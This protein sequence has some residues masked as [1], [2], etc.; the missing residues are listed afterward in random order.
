[1]SRSPLELIKKFKKDISSTDL[2][3]LIYCASVEQ[4]C[5]SM[6]LTHSS[7]QEFQSLLN[8]S[9]NE[10]FTCLMRCALLTQNTHLDHVQNTGPFK[11]LLEALPLKVCNQQNSPHTSV[12][13]YM[14]SNLEP[15]TAKPSNQQLRKTE[16]AQT[17]ILC[18]SLSCLRRSSR[19]ERP[20]QWTG[21]GA[22]FYIH[23]FSDS[24]RVSNKK[25][26]SQ[27]V[28]LPCTN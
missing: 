25:Y 21:A 27:K 16:M 9:L 11:A 14:I 6:V 15:Q 4:M 22:F 1:M 8:F 12:Q 20:V 2:V 23:Q 24:D 26:A 17:Y 7:Q 19:W 13:Y 18:F 10:R 28:R 3:P 5:R